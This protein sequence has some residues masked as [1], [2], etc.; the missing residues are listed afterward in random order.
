MG[1]FGIYRPLTRGNPGWRFWVV[2]VVMLV[3]IIVAV[4]LCYQG[5]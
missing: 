2:L 1:G 4:R 5:A 3:A